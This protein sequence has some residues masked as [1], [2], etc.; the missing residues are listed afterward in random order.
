M[1]V[2]SR[3]KGVKATLLFWAHGFA[4]HVVQVPWRSQVTQS[5][6]CAHL[7]DSNRL[8]LR[9]NV[10]MHH[11][12][13]SPPE[14]TGWQEKAAIFEGLQIGVPS[15]P[16][17][18]FLEVS[19]IAQP[20]SLHS[21]QN[22]P[23]TPPWLVYRTGRQGT[24]IIEMGAEDV[25]GE[26]TLGLAREIASLVPRAS[27]SHLS[28]GGGCLPPRGGLSSPATPAPEI[29]TRLALEMFGVLVVQTA[30]PPM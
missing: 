8:L 17:L 29:L 14:V 23:I 16:C 15:N 28:E 19:K 20:F 25:L 30:V 24:G 22:K 5:A 21:G 2:A 3:R 6:S 10:T 7:E 4:F 9:V 11:W 27:S 18:A 12:E 13:L 26:R 1:E